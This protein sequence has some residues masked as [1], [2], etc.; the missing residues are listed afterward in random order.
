[1]ERVGRT[2]REAFGDRHI[3]PQPARQ[4]EL[5]AASEPGSRAQDL[6]SAVL[7]DEA[8][9]VHAHALAI[10]IELE[11]GGVRAE[12]GDVNEFGRHRSLQGR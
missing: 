4:D 11:Q 6:P 10:E 12:L 2:L 5:E 7:L 9:V 3:G 8:G 1:M